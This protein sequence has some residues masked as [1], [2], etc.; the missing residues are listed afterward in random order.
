MSGTAITLPQR[1]GV[2]GWTLALAA[3][4][5]FLPTLDIVV[6]STALPT[7]RTHLHASLSDL[8]WTIN[9]YNLV[10]A[11]FM[12]TGAALGDRFGR[13]RL[14]VTGVTIF[15]AAS[16]ANAL[17]TTSGELITFRAIQG[18]GA[19]IILPLTVTLV[20]DVMPVEKRAMAIGL[21]GGVT[22]LG[23]AAG[24]VVGGAIVEGISWQWIF[25]LNVPVGIVIAIGSA[26]FLRESKGSRTYL[27]IP[28]L[29][30]A[31][32]A[33]FGLVWA[34]VRGPSIGWRTG[35][36][37]VSLIGGLVLIAAF[38]LW[39]QRTSTPMLPVS[40]FRNRGF[41]GANWASYFMQISII[42]SLFMITQLFQIGMGYSPMT[43]GVRILVWM[44]MPMLVA[45]PGGILAGKLGNRP[46]L[47]VGLTLQAAGLAWLAEAVHVGVGYGSM[48]GPLIVAGIGISLCFPVV[49][50][51]IVDSVPF[52]EIGVAN[53][54]NKTF[55]EL[56]SVSGVAILSAVFAS[57]GG[58][59]SS[60]AFID[61][62]KPAMYTSAALAAVG[63]I[64]ALMLP[65][66]SAAQALQQQAQLKQVA[67]AEPAAEGV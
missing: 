45:P 50:N 19:A 62:F 23:V 66:G 63:L 55:V 21:L 9:S 46:V 54:A 48:V 22:G 3:L 28:G 40:Y 39:E 13:K 37:A 38:I 44:A 59:G 49:S 52:E 17:A 61:G 30:L 16:L 56:G 36:V 24:P 12:L 18:I 64:G 42:G 51:A 53:G 10:F 15:T 8:E 67:Q 5:T 33:M 60:A 27:D 11:V 20:A 58:Y 57:Q 31:G 29:V 32:A 7:L 47:L 4:G 25:W 41:N 2:V 43:T 1:K 14:Y 34:A 6:V 65:R 35:E 26:V